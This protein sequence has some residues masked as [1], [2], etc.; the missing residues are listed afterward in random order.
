MLH[1]KQ[2]AE[3]RLSRAYAVLVTAVAGTATQRIVQNREMMSDPER[4]VGS[5]WKSP[6]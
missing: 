2:H 5:D 1:T 4:P 6:L 3:Q